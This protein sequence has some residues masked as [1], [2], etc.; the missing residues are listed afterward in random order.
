MKFFTASIAI[1]MS[2]LATAYTVSYDTVYDKGW[3]SVSTVACANVLQSHG[4]TTFSSLP[5]FPYIGGAPQI[6][7]WGSP[8]CGTCWIISYTNPASQKTTTIVIT[9]IDVGDPAQEGFNLSLEAMNALTGGQAEYLGRV[10]VGV[11]PC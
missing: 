2:A 10:N 4:Y 1:T 6:T 7:G 3:A 9:A 5:N 11:T 8:Y